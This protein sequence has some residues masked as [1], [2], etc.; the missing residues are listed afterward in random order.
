MKKI[1]NAISNYIYFTMLESIDRDLD[2]KI[3][4][5]IDNIIFNYIENKIENTPLFI[6]KP[7]GN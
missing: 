4:T 6:E 1:R 7:H 5:T 2:S 3:E